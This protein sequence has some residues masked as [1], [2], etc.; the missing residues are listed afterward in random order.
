MDELRNKMIEYEKMAL[1]ADS[2]GD[3]YRAKTYKKCSNVFRYA[4]YH[5]LALSK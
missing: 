3:Y 1:H 2:M 4:Y 5:L